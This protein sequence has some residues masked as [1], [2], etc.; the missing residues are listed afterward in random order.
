SK[1]R[2]WDQRGNDVSARGD[3]LQMAAID[4][5]VERGV[6]LILLDRPRAQP[7]EKLMKSLRSAK[8]GGDALAD[9]RVAITPRRESYLLDAI[10]KKHP[11]VTIIRPDDAI[12]DAHSCG[13]A[14]DGNI[15]YRPDGSHLN[16]EGSKLLGELYLKSRPNPLKSLRRK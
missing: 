14:I 4:D 12:C 11:S 9:I 8:A 1:A 6:K 5:L 3:D 15:L 2:L 16:H 10:A 7:G 13:V